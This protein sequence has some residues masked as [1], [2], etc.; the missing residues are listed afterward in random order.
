ME[1]DKLRYSALAPL[2]AAAMLGGGLAACA[3]TAG[4]SAHQAGV[5]GP[6][7]ALLARMRAACGGDAWDRVQGWHETGQVDMPGRPGLRYDAYHDMRTLKTTYVQR[8]D[9]RIVRLGGYDGETS[10]RVR[11]DGSVER[12]SDPAALRRIRRDMYLSNAAY[13]FPDRFPAQFALAGVHSLNG[14]TFDVLRVTPADAESADLWVDR[15][16]RRVGR[17]VAGNEMAEGSDY[18]TFDGVC[19]PTRL[20]QGDGDPAHEIVLRV[21][22]VETGPIDPARF[23]ASAGAVPR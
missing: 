18:R 14:R 20:R 2:I 12:S 17:I 6:E 4:P 21:E 5:P 11:P 1:L 8:L 13:F 19:T 3:A 23:V 15:E 16:T 22:A 7:A 9:G 10:W